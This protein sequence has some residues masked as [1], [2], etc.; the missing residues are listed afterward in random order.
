MGALDQRVDWFNGVLTST[1]TSS[2]RRSAP[3]RSTI[4]RRRSLPKSHLLDSCNEHLRGRRVP[5]LSPGEVA[6]RQRPDVRQ[7]RLA[8]A[9]R[10]MFSP[11]SEYTPSMADPLY[12]A[13]FYGS[14]AGYGYSIGVPETDRLPDPQW[15]PGALRTPGQTGRRNRPPELRFRHQITRRTLR[16]TTGAAFLSPELTRRGGV[17]VLALPW[18]PVPISS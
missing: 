3:C 8:A 11:R 4:A 1:T 7:A 12:Q 2:V 10:T 17:S 14:A 15:K 5:L 16:S 9:V 18:V 6:P 13:L